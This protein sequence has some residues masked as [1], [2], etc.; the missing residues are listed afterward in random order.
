[1]ERTLAALSLKERLFAWLVPDGNPAGSVFGLITVGAL[2]AAESQIHDTYPEIVG[3]VALAMVLY[4]FAHSYSDLLGRRLTSG[5]HLHWRL[6]LHALGHELAIIKGATLP[7]V[8]LVLC[9]IAGAPAHTATNIAVWTAAASLV[10]VEIAAGVRSRA[11]RRELVIDGVVGVAL[12][13][14]VLAL[15]AV[16]G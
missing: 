12:G 8:A 10:L 7:L 15:R 13:L 14:G 3:S 1:M 4:W 6:I 16:V 5:E 2:V 9:W 11:T